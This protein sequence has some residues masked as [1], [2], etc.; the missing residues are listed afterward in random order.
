MEIEKYRH[1]ILF[2]CFALVAIA[3]WVFNFHTTY[4]P[5]LL[6]PVAVMPILI[7]QIRSR[8]VKMLSYLSLGF[9][10]YLVV[11]QSF[12]VPEG[13][14]EL[15]F[16]FVPFLLLA[17]ANAVGVLIGYSDSYI[18]G[19][20]YTAGA[21]P[22][23]LFGKGPAEFVSIDRFVVGVVLF[24]CS[25]FA[26]VQF[27]SRNK[28]VKESIWSIIEG[29]VVA[30]ILFTLMFSIRFL[31]I[32]MLYPI[33]FDVLSRKVAPL[34]VN[35]LWRL[36]VSNSFVII[37]ALI[38]HDLMMYAFELTREV[39]GEEVFYSKAGV[40][41][42]EMGGEDAFSSFML[43]LRKF[44]QDLPD[45][46]ITAASN[47]LRRFEVEFE[48]LSAEHENVSSEEAKALLEKAKKL[49]GE[50]EESEVPKKE[51][52][53]VFKKSEMIEF[54]KNSTVL[55]EGPIGSRKE[56]YCLRFLKLALQK[57]KN[58]AIC[59]YDPDEELEWFSK[60]ERSRI[61]PFKVE[62]DITEMSIVITKAV[63]SKPELVYFNV[64]YKLLP[65]YS[66]EVLSEFLSSNLR[67]LKK[68]GVTGIF[69]MEKE[70]ISTQLLSVIESLFDGIIEF[71][72]RE[73]GDELVSYYRVKKFKLKEFD[74]N[75]KEF[76]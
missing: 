57:G 8:P 75:W 69:V 10:S 19:G 51:R 2:I 3:V 34:F 59:S 48:A 25:S 70:M 14:E 44:I 40:R 7:R 46:D 76:K 22:A 15:L 21:V 23:L 13:S 38:I 28:G 62:P 52:K 12:I 61:E 56:E 16:S 74:T 37:L 36:L 53:L 32:E 67:K 49:V 4:L 43:R 39:S 20:V 35:L 5:A 18:C 11:A 30:A 71:Q 65:S 42:E 66:G 1:G 31:S 9:V 6:V 73:E 17:V 72:I 29:C 68:G 27:I 55:V 33:Q 50:F 64:L 63:E 24:T 47:V 41:K 58:V 54:P 60:E 45:Y 26:F